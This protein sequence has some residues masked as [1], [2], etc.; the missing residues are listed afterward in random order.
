MIVLGIDLGK[1][2]ALAFLEST[3][4]FLHV[5]KTPLFKSG[6]RKPEYDVVEMRRLLAEYTSRD[7][8]AF[9]EKS[10][11]MP[12]KMGGVAANFHRGYSLGLWTGILSGLGIPYTIVAPRTWQ[13]VMFRDVAAID[14]K[15]ASVMVASRLWPKM[16]WRRSE[17]ARKA[18]HGKTDASLLAEYGRRSL[19]TTR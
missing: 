5:D 17:R 12:A 10:T 3:G 14:T 2:G 9:V 7:L 16:D 6:K 8:T 4:A 15:Q 1:D 13:G 19:G 11:P 18:D